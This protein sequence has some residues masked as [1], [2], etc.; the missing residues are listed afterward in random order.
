MLGK[1]NPRKSHAIFGGGTGSIKKR[2]APIVRSGPPRNRRR[3]SSP[4]ENCRLAPPLCLG[5][6]GDEFLRETAK[7]KIEEGSPIEDRAPLFDLYFSGFSPISLKSEE[8]RLPSH[9]LGAP[10]SNLFYS[11]KARPRESIHEIRVAGRE[12]KG[13]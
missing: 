12:N 5:A 1:K 4:V 9:S 2:G 3:H 8:T 6:P 11:P 10:I 13:D 7:I